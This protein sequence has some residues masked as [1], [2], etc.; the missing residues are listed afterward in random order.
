MKH[1]GS[2]R[3]I[4]LASALLLLLGLLTACG[5]APKNT[6]VREDTAAGAAQAPSAAPQAQADGGT[7]FGYSY[8]TA[9][10]AAAESGV[11]SRPTANAPSDGTKLIHTANLSLETTEFDRAAAGLKTLTEQLGGYFERSEISNYSGD[12]RNAYYSIR[13]PA[14]EFETFCEKAGE[15]SHL[16]YINKSAQD[17]SEQYYDTQIRLETQK[18]KYDRLLALL[19]KADKME[20]IISLENAISETAYQIDQLTGT[21][22]SF[23]SRVEYSSISLQLTEVYRLSDEETAP[24]TFGERLS[25]AFTNGLK[26]TQA[27]FENLLLFLVRNLVGLLLFA[28]V[29]IV[30][31][32]VINRKIRRLRLPKNPPPETPQK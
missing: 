13:I 3:V 28:A 11:V 9:D 4:C 26:R 32:V 27:G 1:T 23:D 20:D 5:A 21:L 7:G 19:E 10:M 25:K 24:I 15:I 8:K 14:K 31:A 2:K 17:V 29:V 22:R 30:A 16:I 12:Y 18:T 6:A